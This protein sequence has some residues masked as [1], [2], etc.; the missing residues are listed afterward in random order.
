MPGARNLECLEPGARSL[1]PGAWGLDKKSP[2]ELIGEGG[3]K[4][5]NEAIYCAAC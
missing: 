2:S 4:R 5:R 1:G 3:K